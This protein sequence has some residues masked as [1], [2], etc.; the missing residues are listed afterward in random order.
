MG[1]NVLNQTSNQFSA[2]KP[3]STK[4]ARKLLGKAFSHFSDDE[5]DRIVSLV[6]FIAK[7]FIIS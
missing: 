4:Q 7:D 5:I 6:N 3:M 2:S 1:R